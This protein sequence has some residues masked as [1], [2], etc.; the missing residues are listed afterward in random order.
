MNHSD[1]LPVVST[2][3]VREP[4]HRA[5]PK[6]A[7]DWDINRIINDYASAAL[8]MQE[9]DMDGVEIEAYGHFLDSFGPQQL[10]KELM[11]MEAIYLIE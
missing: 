3:A 10:I 1:W 5:F 2:S 7:E 4:S 9:A 8:R 6:E 11:L